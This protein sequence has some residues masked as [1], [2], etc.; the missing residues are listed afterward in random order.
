MTSLTST[1]QQQPRLGLRPEIALSWARSRDVGLDPGSAL[2]RLPTAEFDTESRLMAAA[3]PVLDSLRTQL[4]GSAHSVLLADRDCRVIH[5][6]CDDK[7]AESAF[8]DLGV[9]PGASCLEDVVGTNG[10]GTALELRRGVAINGVEHFADGLKPFSC[11][12]RPIH[13]PL[14][15]RVEGVLNFTSVGAGVNPLLAALVAHSVDHIQQRMLDG[16]RSSERRLFAAFQTM[17]AH[18]RH[19]VV[20]LGDN[21]VLSNRAALDL[22]N[23]NDFA[24]LRALAGQ[25]GTGGPGVAEEVFATDF[26]LQNGLRA[27]VLAHA[28]E[29][30]GGGFVFEITPL[31]DAV[32]PGGD[33]GSLREPRGSRL[34]VLISGAPGT[35]RSRAALASVRRHP[36][37]V[38]EPGLAALEGDA[39]WAQQFVE[40][41]SNHS[42]TVVVEEVDRLPDRLAHLV[43]SLA[44]KH[45]RSDL[46]VTSGPV[47]ALTGLAQTLASMCVRSVDLLPLCGRGPS[48]GDLAARIL[49]EVSGDAPLR[50]TPSAIDALT[51]QQW[52]GNFHELRVV[53]TYVASRRSA[54]DVTVGDL[55][56]SHQSA[57]T[58]SNLG[59]LE[60]VE[61]D[62]IMA[63]LADHDGNKMRTAKALGVSRGTLYNR[64][65]SLRITP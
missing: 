5:R 58:P 26:P 8:D 12:G 61:R 43:I 36:L 49:A 9:R 14:T 54:G 35:G 16:A 42:G 59:G 29:A 1:H 23:P 39:V 28:V 17:T 7:Q 56:V 62:A 22:L 57:G 38:L 60:R 52:N 32:D 40:A 3:G 25:G 30:S 34:P 4:A 45:F 20:A 31:T 24:M 19:A 18:R 64:M 2:S 46:I 15:N 6:W 37:T 65:R 41:I 51:A 10:L 21:V 33:R 13:H 50:L 55:P 27:T 11:Y 53:M 63:A 47:D 44:K 48:I